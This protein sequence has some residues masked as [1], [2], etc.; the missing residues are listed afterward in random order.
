MRRRE[1]I[2]FLGGAAA[3]PLAA[4]AQQTAK[5]VVGY[6]GPVLTTRQHWLTAFRRGLGVEGFIDGQ[7]V[8]IEY[9]SADGAEGLPELAAELVRR[10]VTVI[11]ASGPSAALAAKRSTQTI[12]IVFLSGADPVQM[13]LV[14]SFHQPVGN[15]TGFYFL[16]T[17]LVAKRL[18]LLHE[19]LP[20][21]KRVAVLVNPSNAATAEP[22][23]RDVAVA[24]RALG[25]DIQVFNAST[26]GEIDAAF[27]AFSG[28]RPEALFVGPDPLFITERALLVTLAARHALPASYFQR[29]HVEANGLMSY[30]PD[31][32]D[33]YHQ[34][35]VY[36]GRLLKGARP[37]DLP[38][39][40]PTKYEL[41]INL[42]TAK[43]LSLD[44]PAMLL[45][46][47]DEVIE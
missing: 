45:A 27:V 38:V 21:A 40:A 5:P 42:K 2:G 11:F 33:S 31:F 30:G 32:A 37:A 47:A 46:R 16:A 12:P 24:S 26:S 13:G 20:G 35:G 18:A 43:A 44:V 34:A 3:L 29:G 23:V 19:L 9:R 10:P 4:R 1:L 14:S 39:Q 36:V 22:T 8:T 6:L 7:N 28:W 41:V 15:L 17:E 25:L